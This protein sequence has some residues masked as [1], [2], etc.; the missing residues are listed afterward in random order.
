MSQVTLLSVEPSTPLDLKGA[1]LRSTEDSSGREHAFTSLIER[2]IDDSS[3]GNPNESKRQNNGNDHNKTAKPANS[4]AQDKAEVESKQVDIAD[5]TKADVSLPTEGKEHNSKVVEGSA[6]ADKE[7]SLARSNTEELTDKVLGSDGEKIDLKK[8]NDL[9]DMLVSSDKLLKSDTA[10]A[11]KQAKSAASETVLSVDG[12]ASSQ[13]LSTP[14]GKQQSEDLVTSHS[15]S[16]NQVEI[17]LAG[18]KKGNANNTKELKANQLTNTETLAKSDLS[19]DVKSQGNSSNQAIKSD[20]LADSVI[21]DEVEVSAKPIIESDEK[22]LSNV[23]PADKY[24][25]NEVSS[26]DKLANKPEQEIKVTENKVI[27]EIESFINKGEDKSS[28]QAF[29]NEVSGDI[30]ADELKKNVISDSKDNSSVTLTPKGEKLA[31]KVPVG[32]ADETLTARANLNAK[33]EISSDDQTEQLVVKAGQESNVTSQSDSI[34]G[35]IRDTLQSNKNPAHINPSAS[36]SQPVQAISENYNA[37]P[38]I[39]VQQQVS[40]EPEQE[41]ILKENNAAVSNNIFNAGGGINP[42]AVTPLEGVMSANDRSESQ[43]HQHIVDSLNTTALDNTQKQKVQNNQQLDTLNIHRKDFSAAVKEK[44]MVM[45]NQKLQQ[46]EIRLDPPELGN[47][48]VRINLQNEQAAVSFVVQNQQAKEAFDQNLTKLRE[49]LNDSGVDV[50]DAQVSHQNRGDSGDSNTS[51]EGE[52][53]DNQN[54][55]NEDN[56]LVG[57]D[58]DALKDSAKGVDYYA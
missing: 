43:S 26:I 21:T 39:L 54:Q 42:Q 12:R 28:N 4:T 36:S 38:E 11:D 25:K 53:F 8:S 37:D 9:L 56:K 34:K 24:R 31:T 48:H 30:L 2:H 27:N 19:A 29:I 41:V 33:N 40:L 5:D 22:S 20:T 32:L 44:V 52:H 1:A 18:Q 58:G 3:P 46:V 10:S 51:G 13:Q 57:I 16:E 15:S 49:M 23:G 14:T 47:V 45:I 17:E 35:T 6:S 7:N 50:G 55:G